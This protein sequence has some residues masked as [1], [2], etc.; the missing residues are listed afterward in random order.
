MS[1]PKTRFKA[2]SF[3]LL[4]TIIWII[5]HILAAD[6]CFPKDENQMPFVLVKD[7]GSGQP[8]QNEETY[9][10]IVGNDDYIIAGGKSRTSSLNA[11]GE[12]E[13]SVIT[14]IDVETGIHRWSRTYHVDDGLQV[15]SNVL[16]MA[17]EENRDR[18]AV[19]LTQSEEGGSSKNYMLIIN[20]VDGGHITKQ[21]QK[22]VQ[23]A[24]NG[25]NFI[26]SSSAMYFSR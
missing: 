17:L 11:L 9:Q 10:S 4:T 2:T 13:A 3:Y 16:G 19:W 24:E 23:S 26:T 12:S 25:R 22:V 14:R 5:P 8:V 6:K 1:K 18:L 21:A 15:S 20:A 7:N